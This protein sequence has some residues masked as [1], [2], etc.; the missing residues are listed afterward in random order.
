MVESENNSRWLAGKHLSVW[1]LWD[2][3]NRGDWQEIQHTTL[4]RRQADL[5]VDC[6]RTL[7]SEI[8]LSH[9]L[10]GLH[11]EQSLETYLEKLGTATCEILPLAG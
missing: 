9:N 7:Q 1:H 10:S 8:V 2:P 11:F 4:R 5:E 6:K 3:R